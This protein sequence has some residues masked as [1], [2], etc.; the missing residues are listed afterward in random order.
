M[1]YSRTH[2]CFLVVDTTT[3]LPQSKFFANAEIPT[4]KLEFAHT[5]K[6][7]GSNY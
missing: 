2:V 4:P 7:C 3:D 6:L 1:T 5:A